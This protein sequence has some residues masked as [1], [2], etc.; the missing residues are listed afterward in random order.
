MNAIIKIILG[1][2]LIVVP[3]LIAICF[4]SWGR[5]VIELLKGLVIIALIVA[6]ILLLVIGISDLSS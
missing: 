2:I 4:A 1:I 5:A 6:G 3:L